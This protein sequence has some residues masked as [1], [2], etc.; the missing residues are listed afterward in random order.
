MRQIRG[1]VNF[2]RCGE[3]LE[4]E[5]GPV[6]EFQFP[7]L[8]VDVAAIYDLLGSLAGCGERIGDRQD[9][10][11]PLAINVERTLKAMSE[12]GEIHAKIQLPRRLPL[13]VWVPRRR[14]RKTRRQRATVVAVEVIGSARFLLAAREIGKQRGCGVTR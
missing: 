9:V 6:T 13:E 7:S 2:E 11:S 1:D 12:H 10:R 4:I 14:L 5:F 8:V 3:A